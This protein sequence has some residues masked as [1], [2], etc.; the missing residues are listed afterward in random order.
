MAYSDLALRIGLYG[1]RREEA[2]RTADRAVALA[3]DCAD[4]AALG[5][6]Q[7]RIGLLNA[8]L[9]ADDALLRDCLG[10]ART[11]GLRLDAGMAYQGLATGAALRRDRATTRRWVDEGIDYLQVRDILGPLQYLRGL[12][13]AQELAEGNW[14]GAERTAG[15]VLAQPEGRGITGVHA[16]ET[17]ALLH[18][19]RGR[20]PQAVPVLGELWSVAETCGMVQHVAPAACALAEHAELTGEWAAVVTPLRD[21]LALAQRLGLAQVASELGFWLRRAGALD[22][23]RPAPGTPTTPTPWQRR[24][25]GG[26][27]RRCGT[28]RGARS[29]ARAPSPTPTTSRRCSPRS[30]SPSASAPTHWRPGSGRP[31][32]P[33]ARS[34]YRAAPGRTPGP[35]P[36]AS[37]LVSSRSWRY[38]ARG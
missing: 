4:P 26:Q 3:R 18:L 27:R 10:R 25:D 17:E 35:I 20:L 7:G 14:L 12:Q 19:R 13:A 33:A 5:H 21:A 9:D 34:A 15:W 38:C 16:L 8:M 28:G 30:T 11:A 1:G 32:V 24:A 37:P 29:N 6:V 2:G 36:P 23:P 22:P 31:C